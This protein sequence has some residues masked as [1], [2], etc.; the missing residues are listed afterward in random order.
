MPGSSSG[1]RVPRIRARRSSRISSATSI[2]KGSTATALAYGRMDAPGFAGKVVVVTGAGSGIGRAS[3]LLFAKLGAKV[4]V[5]DVNGESAG[6]VARE[7]GGGG[8]AGGGGKGDG[9]GRT[10]SGGVDGV[11]LRVVGGG[12]RV[13]VLHSNAG[14]GHA[15]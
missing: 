6:G 3:A 10:G 9:G 13:D 2:V 15:A 7:I 14:I 11:A 5:A 1:Q 4:H 12:G 8:G